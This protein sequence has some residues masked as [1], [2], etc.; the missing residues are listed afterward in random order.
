MAALDYSVEKHVVYVAS[1]PPRSIFRS[2]AARLNRSIIYLP[3]GALSAE[4]LKRLRVVHILD[5]HARRDEAK[6]FIW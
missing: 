1:K 2:I 6:D 5:S 4:K 3:K